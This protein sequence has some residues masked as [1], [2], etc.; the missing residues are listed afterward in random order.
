MNMAISVNNS[1]GASPLTTLFT[2]R[3]AVNSKFICIFMV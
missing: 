1:V 2:V 3:G